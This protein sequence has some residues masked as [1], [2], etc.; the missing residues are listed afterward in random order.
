MDIHGTLNFGRS[1]PFLKLAKTPSGYTPWCTLMAVK[2]CQAPEMATSQFYDS[3]ALDCFAMGVVGAPSL[4]PPLDHGVF[5]EW[6]W[7]LLVV[8]SCRSLIGLMLGSEQHS[9]FE[10]PTRNWK[11]V[12]AV[13]RWF[14][15]HHPCDGLGSG[16]NFLWNDWVAVC[17]SKYVVLCAYGLHRFLHSSTCPWDLIGLYSHGLRNHV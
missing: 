2:T 17:A 4:G 1:R 5:L 8:L 3:F 12:H 7:N 14:W 15:W 11:K 6:E 9:S 16:W 13:L 10:P